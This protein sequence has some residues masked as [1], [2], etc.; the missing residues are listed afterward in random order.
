MPPTGA[1]KSLEPWIWDAACSIRGAKDA[2]KFKDQISPSRHIHTGDAETHRP[3]A[4]TG[5]DLDA[6]EPEAWEAD[7]AL[8][9]I[10]AT[11]SRQLGW[12]HFKELLPLGQPL[13]RE[14]YAEMCRTGRW[15]VRT[16]RQKIGSM[17]YERTAISR[18]PEEVA[19]AASTSPNISPPS[20]PA[21]CCAGTGQVL[22]FACLEHWR[23]PTIVVP[24]T[25]A[26]LPSLSLAQPRAVNEGKWFRSLYEERNGLT[27]E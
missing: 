7:A 15:S 6:V 23:C 18:K 17:F 21:N 25:P 24:P 5:A 12:S 20:R 3:L 10:V 22:L 26:W 8:R 4:E 11:L 27:I 16:L 1:V 9:E 19:R 13:Q 2:P 14:F